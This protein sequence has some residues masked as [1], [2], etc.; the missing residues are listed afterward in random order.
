M[1]ISVCATLFT[2]KFIICSM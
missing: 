2:H 1:Q